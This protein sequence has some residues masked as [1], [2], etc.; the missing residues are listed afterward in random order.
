MDSRMSDPCVSCVGRN[1]YSDIVSCAHPYLEMAV[2][3][4]C[5]VIRDK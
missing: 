4:T 5:Y 2:Q 3:S 1:S